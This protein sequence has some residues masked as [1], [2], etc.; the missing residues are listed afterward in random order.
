VVKAGNLHSGG[1]MSTALA[2][3][4]TLWHTEG[5]PHRGWECTHVEDLN[6]D[7]L[8]AEEI[9]YETCQA[10]GQHPIRFVHT[11][12]HDDWP[13]E[14]DVG[15]I[16]VEHLTED[17]VNPARRE[18]DLK[19]RAARVKRQRNAYERGR[20]AWA[21][22]TWR[23]SARGNLWTKHEGLSVTVFPFGSGWRI[24]VDGVFGRKTYA[25]RHEAQQASYD[26]V[27]WVIKTRAKQPCGA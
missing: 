11:I 1:M 27:S 20:L 6:P 19:R 2:E 5:F 7:E 16:C 22:R 12:V 26:A 15:R 21:E 14:V 13:D 25:S 9:E 23:T 3:L 18:A 10:C 24:V 8:P 4:G 17:Y